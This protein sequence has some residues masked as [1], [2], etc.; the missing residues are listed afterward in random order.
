MVRAR[1]DRMRNIGLLLLI[2]LGASACASRAPKST[3]ALNGT[4]A[5]GDLQIVRDGERLTPNLTAP[6]GPLPPTLMSWRD[7]Q[8]DHFVSFPRAVTDVEA[9]EYVLPHDPRAD[10]IEKVYDTSKGRSTAD[11]RVTRRRVCRADGGYSDAFSRW[12]D[13]SSLDDITVQLSLSDRDTARKL[14]HRALSDYN[15]RYYRDR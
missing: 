15:R 3:L 6:D 8:G 14:V 9:V 13:G 11:W 1:T 12:V 2:G 7:D 4:Y 10:G 5:C